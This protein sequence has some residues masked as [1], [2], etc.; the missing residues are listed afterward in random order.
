MQLKMSDWFF[1]IC[2]NKINKKLQST[3]PKVNAAEQ[4]EE[5]QKSSS[6]FFGSVYSYFTEP[7]TPRDST[8]SQGD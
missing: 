3:T 5:L 1:E 2:E 4:N 7:T 8:A 6:G